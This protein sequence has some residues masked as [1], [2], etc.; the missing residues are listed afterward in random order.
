M[1]FIGI[2]IGEVEG[3]EGNYLFEP[4]PVTWAALDGWVWLL[5]KRGWG[6]HRFFP[7]GVPS[8]KQVLGGFVLTLAFCKGLMIDGMGG[9]SWCGDVFY[10]CDFCRNLQLASWMLRFISWPCCCV[11]FFSLTLKRSGLPLLD[12]RALNMDNWRTGDP[13]FERVENLGSLDTLLLCQQKMWRKIVPNRKISS[14]H[15]SCQKVVLDSVEKSHL[16]PG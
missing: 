10:P 3:G 1:S 2:S 5:L 9:G 11:C 7:F 14:I 15:I 6:C 4:D 12:P 8:L 13:N 16:D